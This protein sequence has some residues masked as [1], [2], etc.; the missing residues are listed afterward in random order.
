MAKSKYR[1]FRLKTKYPHHRSDATTPRRA[2]RRWAGI[3]GDRMSD[4]IPLIHLTPTSKAKLHDDT[5]ARIKKVIL[6]FRRQ[7]QITAHQNTLDGY[8][9]L[10]SP[11]M[12]DGL[13]ESRMAM[14]PGKRGF[15]NSNKVAILCQ[16]LSNLLQA[17]WQNVDAL[18]DAKEVNAADVPPVNVLLSELEELSVIGWHNVAIVREDPFHRLVNRDAALAESR[19]KLRLSDMTMQAKDLGLVIPPLPDVAT[20]AIS[21]LETLI[22]S[23]LAQQETPASE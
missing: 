14:S 12:A 10:A 20:Q 1:K 9:A 15:L 17:F 18:K 11:A 19:A 8:L 16:M 13:G 3:F 22:Q 5:A 21:L 4:S 7:I 23:Y 2:A 6:S